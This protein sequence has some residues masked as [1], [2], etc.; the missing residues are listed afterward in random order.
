MANT[1]IWIGSQQLI[2]HPNSGTYQLDERGTRYIIKYTGPYATCVANAPARLST[3]A[4]APDNYYV[5]TVTVDKMGGGAAVMTIT[6]TDAPMPGS[7]PDNNETLEVE[8]VEIQKNLL[9]HPV[10]NEAGADSKHPN[11]GLYALTNDD[12]AAIEAWKQAPT[13]NYSYTGAQG[14]GTL[15]TNAQKFADLI[16]GGTDSYVVYSPVIRLTTKNAAPPGNSACGTIQTPPAGGDL[17]ETSN[18]E[19]GELTE[20]YVFLATA[21]RSTRDRVWNRVQEWTGCDQID[22]I[23]YPNA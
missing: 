17:G 20:G 21:D 8:W 11:A 14:N 13:S 9:L 19:T 10:F 4:G 6:L 3:V 5:D 7:G 18:P 16:L 12:R 15:S 2:P 1:P 23:L 22:N